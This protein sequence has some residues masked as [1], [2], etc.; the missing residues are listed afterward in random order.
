MK[1]NYL[2][3]GDYRCIVEEYNTK[4]ATRTGY[5]YIK[6]QLVVE[7]NGKEVRIQKSYCLDVCKN[8][9]IMV[10]LKSIGGLKKKEKRTSKCCTS[11]N[12]GQVLIMMTMEI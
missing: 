11:M 5:S 8:H 7:A 10:L 12:I 4:T 6:L 1:L 3:A 2:K 9:Q